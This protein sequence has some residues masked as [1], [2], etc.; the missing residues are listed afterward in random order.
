[1]ASAKDKRAGRVWWCEEQKSE[2]RAEA[3]GWT[4]FCLE[5]LQ[6]PLVPT[7]L[8]AIRCE[9]LLSTF[10][11]RNKVRI[12]H[13]EPKIPKSTRAQ[14]LRGCA[15]RVRI[16]GSSHNHESHGCSR[17]QGMR[18]RCSKWAMEVLAEITLEEHEVC[19]RGGEI[20][21]CD[22]FS[23]GDVLSNSGKNK[24]LCHVFSLV[25][26]LCPARSHANPS[27]LTLLPRSQVRHVDHIL[28]NHVLVSWWMCHRVICNS[29]ACR[30]SVPNLFRWGR[31]KRR[32]SA[33]KRLFGDVHVCMK[34]RRSFALH[35]C[36][37]VIVESM[38][39]R[40]SW[41]VVTAPLRSSE[42][43]E[44]SESSHVADLVCPPH[45]EFR[46]SQ[47]TREEI[48]ARTLDI[49]GSRRWKRSGMEL[50]LTLLK[51]KWDS[52]AAQMVQRFK[53]TGHPGYKSI[54]ALSRG[55]FFLRHH[56]LQ[57]GCC[58]HRALIPL[59]IYGA[60]SKWCKQFCLTVEERELQRPLARSETFCIFSKTS[61]W[62]QLAENIQDFESLSDTIRFTRVCEDAVFYASGFSWYELQNQTWRG[63]RF[64]RSRPSTPR[65]HTDLLEQ[66][67][68]PESLQQFLEEQPLGQS[69]KSQHGL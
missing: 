53:D 49:S 62:K 31:A 64:W 25:Q 27:D 63:R 19:C 5:T 11:T 51:E 52:A 24:E 10:P 17:I 2:R 21:P 60:V 59:S 38:N 48:L 40:L 8:R 67:Q 66:A 54:S 69:L 41:L 35:R 44:S 33:A 68:N 42:K 32:W 47:G 36:S 4:S 20:I 46:K 3:L 28:S 29:S 16:F 7:H 18:T 13:G 58:K 9:S 55:I 1:M 14:A 43:Q 50:F 57:C 26:T 34:S 12:L 39:P 15:A 61:I 23:C 56:T 37:R 6:R 65:I 22:T 30:A 45:V